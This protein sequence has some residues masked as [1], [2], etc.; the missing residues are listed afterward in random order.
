MVK[1]W[2]LF[3]VFQ[4]K[5]KNVSFNLLFIIVLDVLARRQGEMKSKQKAKKKKLKEIHIMRVYVK[6]PKEAT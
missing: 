5:S 4:E 3:P 6:N 2:T 1:Y